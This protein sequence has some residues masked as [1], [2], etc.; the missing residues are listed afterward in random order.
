M[1]LVQVLLNNVWAGINQYNHSHPFG[2]LEAN[3]ICRQVGYTNAVASDVMTQHSLVNTSFDHCYVDN[4]KRYVDA[5]SV[6]ISSP[7]PFSGFSC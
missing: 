1:G 6:L 2:T 4:Q 5:K 3:S 7:G